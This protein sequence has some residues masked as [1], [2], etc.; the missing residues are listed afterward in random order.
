[1]SIVATPIGNAGDITLR[2]LDTL[3]RVAAVVCEDTRVTSKL[4]AI[5]AIRAPMIAYHDHNAERV[6]PQLVARLQAGEALALVSDAGTPLVSD[7]GYK[8]VRACLDAGIAVTAL[9]GASAMLAAL[10]LAGLPTDRFFF[11]GFLPAKSGARRTEIE[12]L[13]AIPGTLVIYESPQRLAEC[14]ADLA[15]LLGDRPAA[16]T[17]ELTKRFE[18]ARRGRLAALAKHYAEAETP[19]GE[20]VIV[21]GPP[22]EK[23]DTPAD[24][25]VDALLRKALA[26]AS[27]R[28]AVDA[29]AV[30]TGLKRRHVYQRALAL[31]PPP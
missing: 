28:D 23:T 31:D 18:E 19:K 1:L 29:V 12:G 11:A 4:F 17:R 21:I 15:A 13:K 9:P 30:A 7:P 22:E 27:L 3:G 5:H 16:V 8:L 25:D 24:A 2:A 26:G 20:V 6:R 10:V 14:L